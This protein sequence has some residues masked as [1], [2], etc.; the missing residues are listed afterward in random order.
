MGIK[1]K[2]DL[3]GWPGP[4]LGYPLVI[5]Y[6]RYRKALFSMGKSTISM[7]IFHSYVAVYQRV[8]LIGTLFLLRYGDLVHAHP[9]S[10]FL[11]RSTR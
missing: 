11:G 3:W 2:Q 6:H 9:K 8:D 7:A 5:C 4:L 1:V 10:C